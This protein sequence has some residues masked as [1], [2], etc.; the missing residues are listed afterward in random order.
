MNHPNPSTALA[1]TVVDELVRGGLRQVVIAPG[2]RSAA[3]ALAIADRP[4]IDI[5]VV[6]DERSAGFWALG[7]AR[8][9]SGPVAVLVTSGTAVANLFP[10]V[11]EA[12]LARVPL[13]VLSANRPPALRAVGSNQTIDQVGLF[14]SKVRWA[15]EI[16]APEG[17][18]NAVWRS[19]ASRLMAEA[20]GRTPGPVHL[21]LGF[22]EPLVPLSDDGRAISEP[23]LEKTD[24]RWNGA[25]WTEVRNPPP[26]V[27]MMALPDELDVE[28]GVVVVGDN[29][30][31]RSAAMLADYQGW[32]LIAEPM[33]SQ[34]HGA[35]INDSEGVRSTPVIT[36]AHHLL[37]HAGFVA[38]HRPDVV[39]RYGGGG[40]SRNLG[41]FCSGAGTLVSVDPDGWHDPDRS[42]HLMLRAL[43]V[44]SRFDPA[45][46]SGW[47]RDW[48]RAEALVRGVIDGVL[49]RLDL[50]TEPRTARDA[51]R[52]VPDR[53][54]MVV[55]SS[56]PIR[57]LDMFMEARRMT[58]F[59]NRGAS[60]IDGFVSTALGVASIEGS[61]PVALAGDLS[62]LHDSNGFLTDRLPDCV[63]VV[64]NNNGGGIFSFLPQARLPEHFERLFGTPHGREFSDLARFH[65]LGYERIERSDGLIPAIDQ[66][67][68]SGGIALL[69]VVTD[70]AA[71]VEVHR[72][73]GAGVTKALDSITG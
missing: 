33:S 36:T 42:A 28:A 69:E 52:A 67:R 4:E 38:L 32:P 55:A 19:V 73:L 17:G 68:A 58:V 53:G 22:S 57:D 72:G 51:A 35:A 49:D 62:L 30:F 15:A 12:D 26:G 64:V 23:F 54:R 59:A 45:E 31:A 41:P 7:M 46:T 29:R 61:V 70:R 6:I 10:A 27:P 1:R 34:R 65:R 56:M 11:V 43:P 5:T 47:M 9:S 16:A 8:A 2:S 44:S 13:I 21:D 24:G 60:G 39:I 3:M 48:N 20:V 63:F 71:N 18:T 25:S 40:V 66:A 50:P 37:G 14:G